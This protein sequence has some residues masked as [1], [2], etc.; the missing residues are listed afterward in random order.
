[1]ANP[2]VN[3]KN[4]VNTTPQPGSISE[5]YRD[6]T[7]IPEDNEF[8]ADIQKGTLDGKAALLAKWI[9]QK[10]WGRDVR[11]A[12]ALFV[13]WIT[14][15]FNAV[16]FKV[17]NVLNR[18]DAVEK[19]QTDVEN[20]LNDFVAASTDP[21]TDTGLEVIQARDSSVYGK[22]PTLDARLESLEQALSTMVP[23]GFTVKIQHDL[24]RNPTI[25]AEYY[26]YAIG[27]EP[28]GFATG[29]SGTFCGTLP[30]Q[31]EIKVNYIDGNNCEVTMPKGYAFNGI[32]SQGP[33]GYWYL[34]EGY[35]TVRFTLG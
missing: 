35:K 25:T 31:L 4:F 19:R 16:S 1:M 15:K 30:K 18:Q 23:V 6:S 9:R 17:Q 21:K 27:T 2:L 22:F 12:L 29:P 32:V 5:D 7:H 3:D 8:K 26:E 28:D 20:Q 10:Q 11:E 34:T 14:V 13:E 33:D 24:G